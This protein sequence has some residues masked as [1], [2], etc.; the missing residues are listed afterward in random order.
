MQPVIITTLGEYSIAHGDNIISEKDKRSKKMWLLLKYLTAFMDRG[1]TQGELIEILWDEKEVNNPS[2]AL[3][4]QLHRIRGALDALGLDSGVELVVSFAG[5]YA[6]NGS[7]E[8]IV[9]ASLFEES[10]KKSL[11][12]DLSEKE[13]VF[14]AKKAFD[15]YGGD[16]L[17]N[18]A[19]EKWVIPMRVYYHSI[20]IRIV[21][22]LID[23]LYKY[24]QYT[25]L[26]NICQKALLID[27]S[28][29]KIHML[30]IKA[31]IASGNRD[32]AKRHYKYIMDLLYNQLGVNP[33]PELREL[34]K[35]TLDRET[36]FENDLEVIKKKLKE[37]I[38][39]VGNGAFFC[40]FEFF[41]SIYRLKMR[42]AERTK[43]KTQICLITVNEYRETSVEPKVIIDVMKRL[44][45]CIANSLRK[46]DIFARYSLTQYVLML[47]TEFEETAEVV[48]NRIR[49][50]YNEEETGFELDIDFKQTMSVPEE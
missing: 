25:E 10:F 38:N 37:D 27:G 41:K 21:H 46:S 1:V 31:L 14:Y 44:H 29:Q 39:E 12:D 43:Q 48:V 42:D 33:L 8:Y 15:L 45:E 5:T 11:R 35:E 23:A 28:D 20:Y 26:I 24:K 19:E 49:N 30:L 4:T 7:L 40:E 9:D 32:A 17:K 2:G 47:P 13:Q 22:R 36:D 6:F 18:S 50:R 34:Y 16:F 3:K